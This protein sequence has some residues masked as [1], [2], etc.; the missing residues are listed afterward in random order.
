MAE[1]LQPSDLQALQDAGLIDRA[2]RDEISAFLEKRH[3]D[4]A[5][6]R[7]DLTHVLWYV[8]ALIIIGAMGLFTND[9]FNRMGG[10]ALTTCGVTYAVVLGLA[11]HYLW[12]RKS[13]RIPGGLLIAAAVS[14]VPM[15]IY[16]IQ[17]ALDL[18][19]Y[20]QGDPGEY[21]NVF[22]YIHGSWIYMEIAT[23]SV[24][25]IAAY[26]YRFSFI[27]LIAAV[28]LWF[29]SMDVAIWFLRSPLNA[30]DYSFDFNTRR[31]VSI[32]VGLV[33]IAASWA[34][35]LKRRG[36]ADMAFW[37]HLAG[38]AAFWGGLT[39]S[40]GGTEL[41]KFIYLLINIGL[42]G[43]SLFLN[44]RVYAVFGGLGIATYLG[45]LAFNT[46][47]DMILFS[48]AL[49]AIGLLVI[50]LGLMLLRNRGRLVAKLDE[51][52]PA[53]IKRLRPGP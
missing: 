31:T 47:K 18:W 50:F 5:R 48:F 52:L 4:Q 45:Q 28:A 37:L 1:T 22:P 20:A 29:F 6:P 8:G 35:D 24:A 11:G 42:L 27:L 36:G 17:D 14:M 9:A 19:K 40:D 26:F 2:K 43:L 32:I 53:F 23:V 46:F 51:S 30:N 12:T 15:I 44:R 10:W 13:L 21:G 33:I 49:S 7:F 41:Q 25:A 39:A 34:M 38:A 16:G 3:G